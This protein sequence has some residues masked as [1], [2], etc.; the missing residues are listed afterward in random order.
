MEAIKEDYQAERGLPFI[1][2]FARDMRF[3]LRLL[4]RSP[5]SRRWLFSR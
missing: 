5:V 3:A 4:R 2:T 1:H